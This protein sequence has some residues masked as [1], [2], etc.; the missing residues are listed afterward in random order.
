M[1]RRFEP[2]ESFRVEE[3]GVEVVLPADVVAG[4]DG[5]AL[6]RDDTSDAIEASEGCFACPL[7]GGRRG[8]DASGCGVDRPEEDIPLSMF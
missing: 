2:E 5:P 3:T 6:F 4:V 8:V 1:A 7:L